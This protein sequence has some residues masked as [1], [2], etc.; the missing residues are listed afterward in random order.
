M[1]AVAF[2][3]K[4]MQ[5]LIS[6]ISNFAEEFGIKD[7]GWVKPENLNASLEKEVYDHFKDNI[8]EAYLISD[9]A[10][11]NDKISEIKSSAL[12]KFNNQEEC[13]KD[14][15]EDSIHDIQKDVVRKNIIAGKPRIDGRDNKTIRNI[16]I[17]VGLYPRLME[18]L[19]LPEVKHRQL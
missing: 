18:V 15:I 9:K 8:T 5:G 1:G 13:K 12:E 14:C 10:E 6:E 7:Y 16:N 2:G 4:E 17:E 19:Y 11:R 3:H